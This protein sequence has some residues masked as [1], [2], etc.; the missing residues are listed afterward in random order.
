[1]LLGCPLGAHEVPFIWTTLGSVAFLAIFVVISLFGCGDPLIN[2]AAADLNLS[3]AEVGTGFTLT[4][5]RGPDTANSKDMRDSNTRDFEANGGFVRSVV[6]VGKQTYSDMP[7]ELINVL[8]TS[9]QQE[10]NVDVK[11]EKMQTMLIGDRGGIKPFIL[12]ATAG[13]LQGYV[14]AFVKRNVIVM[15]IETGAMEQISKDSVQKHA[16]LIA[17]RLP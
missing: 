17:N 13:S 14:V 2:K 9:M 1:M 7:E 8:E 6:V 3:A 15:I 10:A 5:E 4:E 16:R 11:F 12:K